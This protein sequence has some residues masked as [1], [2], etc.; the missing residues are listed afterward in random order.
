MALD[1]DT[2][3]IKWHVLLRGESKANDKIIKCGHRGC[4]NEA[5]GGQKEK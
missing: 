5:T 4:R 2:R 3:R 1:P